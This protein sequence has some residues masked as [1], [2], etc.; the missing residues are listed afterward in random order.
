MPLSL[1]QEY[2]E[3]LLQQFLR[4]KG[5]T[6]AVRLWRAA[7]EI[8]PAWFG[9]TMDRARSGAREV[10]RAHIDLLVRILIREGD[11]VAAH[12]LGDDIKFLHAEYLIHQYAKVENL[13]VETLYFDWGAASNAFHDVAQKLKMLPLESVDD[14]SQ[15]LSTC[16]LCWR[17]A[18]LSSNGKYYCLRHKPRHN[19]SAYKE[20]R[21]LRIWRSPTQDPE[22]AATFLYERLRE[23]RRWAPSGMAPLDKS[24][25]LLHRLRCG[26]QSVVES[27]PQNSIQ[28][29][30]FW[31]TF[32]STQR[33]L[34]EAKRNRLDFDDPAD[35]VVTL[36]PLGRS[37]RKLHRL[38]HA[39][40]IRDQ[41][42]LIE[43][44]QLAETWLS[45]VEVRRQ[46]HGGKRHRTIAD[47]DVYVVQI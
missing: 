38:V 32:S 45:A 11:V 40:M 22:T 2:G 37:Q 25:E 39:A 16:H 21:K 18:P 28:L 4:Q 44:L 14:R 17:T 5:K 15:I 26:E 36:D 46:N 23:L 6:S 42:L 9:A 8:F 20:A 47:P 29:A 31:P 43:M 27:F 13:P 34:K 12:L 19:N 24:D 41:R 1:E 10:T 7:E 30:A 3:R 35:I 33:F